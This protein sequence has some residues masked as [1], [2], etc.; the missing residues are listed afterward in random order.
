MASDETVEILHRYL[1]RLLDAKLPVKGLVLYGSYARGD[2]RPTSD[3][4]VLVLL[5]NGLSREEIFQIWPELDFL[6][7]SI[8][9]RIET[10]PVTE[11]SFETDEVSPLILIARQE[12]IRIA[13]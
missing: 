9:N 7:H 10:W 3:I 6:T 13:A 11:S 2:A 8:D 1:R 4:D 5:D 12:G